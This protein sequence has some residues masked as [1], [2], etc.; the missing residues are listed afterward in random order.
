VSE[1][2]KAVVKITEANNST[3]VGIQQG[4]DEKKTAELFKEVL[5][6]QL[7]D[8]LATSLGTLPRLRGSDILL[9]SLFV[10][11]SDQAET[12]GFAVN[13][14]GLLICPSAIGSVKTVRNIKSLDELPAR[15]I[16]SHSLLQTIR[17]DT[18]TKGLVP[19]YVSNDEMPAQVPF[20]FDNR[21]K[22]CDLSIVGMLRWVRVRR[23][24]RKQREEVITNV[25]LTTLPSSEKLVG[26][27][28]FTPNGE[29]MGVAL[30]CSLQAL[31]ARPWST[32]S[33][34]IKMSTEQVRV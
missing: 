6:G 2:T 20:V 32:V 12:L 31:I 3:I 29:V 1:R 16:E 27:P 26:G 23:G 13:N 33:D 21:G 15:A 8:L 22:R 30:A 9:D 4:L 11:A 28:V 25:L 24:Q 5:K 7:E 19:A 14:S 18:Q 17:L 34:C 10:C